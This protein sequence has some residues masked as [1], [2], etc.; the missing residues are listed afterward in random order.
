MSLNP[1]LVTYFDRDWKQLLLVSSWVMSLNPGLVTYS[2]RDWKQ[3]L[4][5]SSWVMSLNPG[6]SHNL[7]EIGNNLGHECDLFV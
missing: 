4:F 3:L 1:G 6:L 2:E 5:V 7:I